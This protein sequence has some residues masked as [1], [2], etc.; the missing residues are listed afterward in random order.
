MNGLK[1]AVH[2]EPPFSLG[3][4]NLWSANLDRLGPVGIAAGRVKIKVKTAKMEMLASS[5]EMRLGGIRG[6]GRPKRTCCFGMALDVGE[7]E[8]RPRSNQ[9]GGPRR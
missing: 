6:T 1:T 8:G 2:D 5:N 7:F 4:E 9:W 3:M